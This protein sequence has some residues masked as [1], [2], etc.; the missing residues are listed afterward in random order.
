MRIILAWRL[1]SLVMNGCVC[2]A[3]ELLRFLREELSDIKA[4]MFE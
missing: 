2:L 1:L 4:G 3:F